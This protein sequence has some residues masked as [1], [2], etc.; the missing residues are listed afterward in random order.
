[1]RELAT[2]PPPASASGPRA[3][4]ERS[5]R[6]RPLSARLERLYPRHED[7]AGG[8]R[9]AP[10]ARRDPRGD[11]RVLRCQRASVRIDATNPDTARGLIRDEIL[12]CCAGCTRCGGQICARRGAATP[13][14]RPRE[15]ARRTARLAGGNEG[16]RPRRRHPSPREYDV[17]RLEGTASGAGPRGRSPRSEGA[18]ASAGGSSG[19]AAQ[20]GAGSARDAKVPRAERDDWPVVVS[21]EDVVAVPGIAVAPGWEGVVTVRRAAR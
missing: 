6:D 1:M 9:R 11:K 15:L 7:A 21:G 13:P 2:R 14:A 12:P 3:H 20:E 8:W 19:R 16:G 17:P 10:A 4:C 18:G 5:G